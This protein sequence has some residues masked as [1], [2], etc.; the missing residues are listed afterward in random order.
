MDVMSCIIE[1]WFD[2]LLVTAVRDDAAGS[3]EC[4]C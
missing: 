1:Q 4:G 3:A 2:Y